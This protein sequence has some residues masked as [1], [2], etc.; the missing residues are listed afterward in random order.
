MNHLTIIHFTAF[1]REHRETFITEEPMMLHQAKIKV[2]EFCE[3]GV[4]NKIEHFEGQLMNI[5]IYGSEDNK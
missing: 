5:E 2:K 1:N 4:I 3:A